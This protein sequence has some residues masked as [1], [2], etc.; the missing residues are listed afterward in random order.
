MININ[1][2]LEDKAEKLLVESGNFSVPV[3]I[4]ECAKHLNIQLKSLELDEDVSGFLV[5]K[6]DNEVSIGYN[7]KN[8][9]PRVRFTIAHEL[10]HFILHSKSSK[11][12]VDKAEKILYRNSN[13]ST[14]ELLQEREAN[15]FAAIL[16]MPQKLI[17][18]EVEKLVFKSETQFI[19]DLA[20]KF[21]VS[22]QAMTIRLTNLGII[23]YD[24]FSF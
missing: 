11:L 18:Q 1:P 21:K 9:K 3:R 13:S 17:I 10:G 20:N 23:D 15:A 4:E 12:F 6:A 8:S 24:T 16:L 2:Y 7:K 5:I 14:G 22:E 19:K